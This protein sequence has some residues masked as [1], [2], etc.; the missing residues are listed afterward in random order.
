MPKNNGDVFGA[1]I[2]VLLKAPNQALDVTESIAYLH[3]VDDS[4]NTIVPEFVAQGLQT[5]AGPLSGAKVVI[6]GAA[7][8]AALQTQV[9]AL[10]ATVNALSA[11]LSGTGTITAERLNVHQIAAKEEGNDPDNP[12]LIITDAIDRTAF[13]I[14]GTSLTSA[15]SLGFYGV[16]PTTQPSYPSPT[17]SGT[18]VAQTVAAT[19]LTVSP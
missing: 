6:P 9:G 17:P 14:N 15:V 5:P 12:A 19:G 7:S 1:G 16:E 13:G 2:R 3:F 10:Q 11:M 4:G 8:I 18:E